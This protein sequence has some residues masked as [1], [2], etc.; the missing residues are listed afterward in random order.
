MKLF[1]SEKKILELGKTL[2]QYN[3]FKDF[4]HKNK[5]DLCYKPNTQEFWFS[6]FNPNTQANYQILKLGYGWMVKFLE[7]N[8]SLLESFP[9]GE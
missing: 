8:N 6:R 1:P 4:C 7:N 3:Q 2:D 9:V 5:I